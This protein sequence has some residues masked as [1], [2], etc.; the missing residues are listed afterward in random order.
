MTSRPPFISIFLLSASALAYEIL[1]IH[2][3]SIIRY[4]HFAYMIISL[5]L[6]GY[7]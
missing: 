4:H 1:L 2:L 7:V 3:F 6:L 5:A